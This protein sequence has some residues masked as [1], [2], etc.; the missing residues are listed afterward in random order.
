MRSTQKQFF[1]YIKRVVDV[2]IRIKTNKTSAHT[3]CIYIY[4]FVTS[5]FFDFV[6]LIAI[7]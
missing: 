6:I 1:D 4:I 5:R 7:I 3:R 2:F